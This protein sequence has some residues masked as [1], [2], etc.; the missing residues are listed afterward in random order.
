METG[1]PAVEAATTRLVVALERLFQQDDQW[2]P[3]PS[4]DG[5]TITL[6]RHW[7]DATADTVALSP[8]LTYAV[9]QDPR[10]QEI[11]RVEGTAVLV[12]S[13]VGG[14]PAT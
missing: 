14:W 10:K 2:R 4:T 3:V 6:T 12:V 7:Q 9:R 5:A 1:A 8:D 13:A 11:A